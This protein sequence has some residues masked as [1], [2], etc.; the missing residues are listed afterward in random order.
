MLPWVYAPTDAEALCIREALSWVW[1]HG[2]SQQ[3][4]VEI[5]NL[6]VVQAIQAAET[7]KSTLGLVIGDCLVSCIGAMWFLLVMF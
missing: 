5:D 7:D 3:F 6:L 2:G 4:H 1:A